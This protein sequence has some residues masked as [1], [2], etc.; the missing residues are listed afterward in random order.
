MR[1]RT[2][3]DMEAA[4]VPA[5]LLQRT[6]RGVVRGSSVYLVPRDSGE[7]VVGATQEELGPDTR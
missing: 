3:A 5:G 6:V 4:G 1:L 2:T 7:L